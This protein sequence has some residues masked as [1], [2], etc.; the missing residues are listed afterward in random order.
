M[1]LGALLADLLAELLDPQVLDE[2]RAKE[3]RDQHRGH[4]GDQDLAAIDRG[5]GELADDLSDEQLDQLPAPV[6]ATS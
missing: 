1:A 5:R 6:R 3:D 4:P 2:L